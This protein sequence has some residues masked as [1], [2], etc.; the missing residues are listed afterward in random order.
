MSKPKMLCFEQ[1]NI[2]HLVIAEEEEAHSVEL[3]P[4]ITAELNAK[5]EPAAWKQYHLPEDASRLRAA[6][7]PMRAWHTRC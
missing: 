3:T 4:N 6:H 2:L 5:G 1:E 7:M